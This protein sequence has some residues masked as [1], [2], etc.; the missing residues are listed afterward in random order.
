MENIELLFV[1]YFIGEQDEKVARDSAKLYY[2]CREN[3]DKIQQAVEA[4]C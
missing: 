1:G 4:R 2:F 3:K